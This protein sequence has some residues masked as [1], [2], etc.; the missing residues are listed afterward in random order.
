MEFLTST[1]LSGLLYG[2]LKKGVD[3]S[4]DYIKELLRD[5][6]I[7]DATAG[8]VAA[9]LAEQQVETGKEYCEL[10]ET[11][12]EEQLES[13]PELIALIRTIASTGQSV[14][15][16]NV[17]SGTGDIVNGNKIVRRLWASLGYD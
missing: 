15:N 2:G 3:I 12:I 11:A 9:M 8:K 7:D 14:V 6:V 13:L 5:W 1:I 10:R 16:V 17:H 4:G